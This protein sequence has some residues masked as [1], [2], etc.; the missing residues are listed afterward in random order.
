MLTRDFH[1]VW[2]DK[3][4]AFHRKEAKYYIVDHY[5]RCVNTPGEYTPHCKE[6]IVI[7]KLV[8]KCRKGTYVTKQ[9]LPTEWQLVLRKQGTH[10]LCNTSSNRDQKIKKRNK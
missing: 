3:K 9:A 2:Y 8:K 4:N 1:I 6:F 10:I 5:R 7:L